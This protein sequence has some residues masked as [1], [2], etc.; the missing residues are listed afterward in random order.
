MEEKEKQK[1]VCTM[2]RNRIGESRMVRNSVVSMSPKAMV[3]SWPM[4]LPMVMSGSTVLHLHGSV[5]TK[6]QVDI[7]DLDCCMGPYG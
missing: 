5:T 7:P 2:K 3:R 1:N 4:L 6:G